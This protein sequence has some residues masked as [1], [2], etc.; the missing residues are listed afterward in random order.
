VQN[1]IGAVAALVQ[2]GVAPAN[3]L[4]ALESF[5]GAARRFEW[6]GEAAGVT[7]IDD[8]AHNPPKVRAALDAAK[9]RFPNRRLVVYVQPHTF[10]RTQALIDEFATAF[11]AADVLLVGDIYR[12][13]ERA[14]DFPG[15]DAAFVVQHLRHEAAEPSGDLHASTER[16]LALLHPG[17]VLLTLGA[18]DGNKV[19]E[20]VLERL[21]AEG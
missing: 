12:S 2:F 7:V 18:G 4:Q 3:A 6:K 21:K 8:Y 17:D 15:I 20:W 19:G 13:R 16:I 10:S 11:D 5:R 9:M 1:A 14:E